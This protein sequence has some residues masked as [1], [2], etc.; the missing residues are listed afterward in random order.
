[1]DRY[2]SEDIKILKNWQIKLTTWKI[3]QR[4]NTS[5]LRLP[6]NR[7]DRGI[8]FTVDYD[9]AG[10]VLY[11]TPSPAWCVTGKASD[12][13]LWILKYVK[14]LDDKNRLSQRCLALKVQDHWNLARDIKINWFLSLCSGIQTNFS[15][16]NKIVVRVCHSKLSVN[17]LKAFF[18]LMDVH[19]YFANEC[20]Y[21]QMAQW[22]AFVLSFLMETFIIFFSCK[23]IKF[24][25]DIQSYST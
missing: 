20:I 3:V 6:T 11:W 15:N 14:P 12:T 17:Q 1:M 25:R 2:C 18:L 24:S 8:F 10:P 5:L 16:K 4:R 23:A 13:I 9:G 21:T 22:F 19:V 7:R